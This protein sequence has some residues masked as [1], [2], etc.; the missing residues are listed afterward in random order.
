MLDKYRLLHLI[1][2]DQEI[3]LFIPTTDVEKL[4]NKGLELKLQKD[5][6]NLYGCSLKA[7]GALFN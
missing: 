2:E 1:V 4:L 7:L 5:N 6:D 3:T